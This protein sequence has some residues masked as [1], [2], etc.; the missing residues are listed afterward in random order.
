MRQCFICNREARGFGYFNPVY[1]IN[2]PLR[3][4]TAKSFCTKGCQSIFTK[5]LKYKTENTMK[6]QLTSME[7][8]ARQ[9][10][11]EPL[12]DYVVAI[13][14]DKPLANYSRDEING[15]VAVVINSYQKFMQDQEEWSKT[16][17]DEVPF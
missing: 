8:R 2:N 7:I 15:L 9:S 4:S 3:R 1:S 13:G 10:I 14:M 5:H 12:G 17:D 11:L 6:Q 16:L